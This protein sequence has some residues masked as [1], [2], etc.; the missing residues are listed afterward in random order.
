MPKTI[1]MDLDYVDLF[2]GAG[3]WDVGAA[4]LDLTGVGIEF[5]VDI[6]ATR[7]AAGLDTLDGD[8][9][10]FDPADFAGVD[11]LLGSPPCQSFSLLGRRTGLREIEK[12][13]DAVH[14]GTILS[15][16][17]LRAG[18]VVAP[19][20]WALRMRPRALAFEQVPM[21]LPVWEACARVL[22][23]HGYSTWVGKLD[24]EAYGVPQ[25]RRRAVLLAARDREVGPP[26]PTHSR[27]HIH[28]PDRFDPEVEPWV[29][30]ARAFG[31][32]SERPFTFLGDVKTSRGT[33]RDVDRPA[34]TLLA[35]L[36]N[37]NYR[38]VSVEETRAISPS[39]IGVL[40]SF[41]AD[42]PWQGSKRSQFTQVGNAVPPLL[43]TRIL[44]SLL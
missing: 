36:D 14:A 31:W 9:R 20:D 8:V 28:S 22:R 42:H 41:P 4:A 33:M 43:S 23:Q 2:A 34:P 44:E 15:T 21:V 19:L 1:I 29:S 13:V 18:L 38:W 3:G 35:S 11:L 32:G 39:E 16:V 26:V 24:A 30:I 25:T 5:D 7:K 10:A 12:I 40:Q 17:D 27:Y 6:C 37:G